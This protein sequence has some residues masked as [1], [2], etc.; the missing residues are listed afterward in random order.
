MVPTLLRLAS[1]C[2]TS[3][4]E[5]RAMVLTPRKNLWTMPP[6]N[7]GRRKK[8]KS[9][10][11]LPIRLPP[12]ME[13][14]TLKIKSKRERKTLMAGM[15]RASTKTRLTGVNLSM[16]LSTRLTQLKI[17]LKR[18]TE[19]HPRVHTLPSSEATSPSVPSD[20]VNPTLVSR[21]PTT[22]PVVIELF[23]SQ[24]LPW[25][26]IRSPT[27]LHLPARTQSSCNLSPH[28]S[29]WRS[30]AT[31]S[32]TISKHRF[33]LQRNLLSCLRLHGCLLPWDL[34]SSWHLL[35]EQYL[36]NVFDAILVI[37]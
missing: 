20:K 19:S 3:Q 18:A 34:S 36:I 33:S 2:S 12:L 26:T 7:T 16:T 31:N 6:K 21:I 35:C 17:R 29:P 1:R 24:L 22:L 15:A 23:F 37:F 13:V 11:V 8:A 25:R 30:E 27:R 5:R 10:M 14:M 9:L 4:E 32:M 28:T